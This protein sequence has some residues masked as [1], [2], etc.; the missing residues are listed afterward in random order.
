MED[1]PSRRVTVNKTSEPRIYG[2]NYEMNLS[3]QII[4]DKEKSE[5]L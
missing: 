1:M 4:N 3:H 5:Q 2:K